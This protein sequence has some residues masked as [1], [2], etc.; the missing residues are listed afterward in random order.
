MN[1]TKHSK[2]NL[3]VIEGNKAVRYVNGKREQEVMINFEAPITQIKSDIEWF[4][5]HGIE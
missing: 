5:I 4:R 1:N 2:L 3:V